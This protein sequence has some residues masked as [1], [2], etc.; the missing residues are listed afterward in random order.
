MAGTVIALI[1]VTIMPIAFD[2]LADLPE[3]TA[4][5]ASPA[6][7]FATLMATVALA[8]CAS[9]ALRIWAPMIGIAVGCVVASFLLCNFNRRSGALRHG[10]ATGRG[11]S[12]RC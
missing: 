9:G 10:I 3:G 6:S 11:L 1:A 5:A 7:A 4:P 12:G 8:L 2:M